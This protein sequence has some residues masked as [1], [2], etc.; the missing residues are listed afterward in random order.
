MIYRTTVAYYK[1]TVKIT[2]CKYKEVFDSLYIK[3]QRLNGDTEIK[4]G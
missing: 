3:A 4:Y 1:Q 2:S